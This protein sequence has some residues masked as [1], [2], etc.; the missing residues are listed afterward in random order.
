LNLLLELIKDLKKNE[1]NKILIEGH[2]CCDIAEPEPL[3]L[4][5]AKFIND[6]LV[7][8]GIS[9]DRFK[10]IGLGTKK[11]LFNDNKNH[12]KNRRVEIYS[13]Y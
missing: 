4:K 6:Y 3:S 5:R 10:I 1:K 8:K 13:I 7:K 2:T 9:A 12:K 11:L